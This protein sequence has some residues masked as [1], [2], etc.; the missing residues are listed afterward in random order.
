MYA[1]NWMQ[2]LSEIL[3]RQLSNNKHLRWTVMCAAVKNG[4]E[5]LVRL[6]LSGQTKVMPYVLNPEHLKHEHAEISGAELREIIPALDPAQDGSPS[7]AVLPKSSPAPL[8]PSTRNQSRSTVF[9]DGTLDEDDPDD[10]KEDLG[11]EVCTKSAEETDECLL[12]I[13]IQCKPPKVSIVTMLLDYDPNKQDINR[14]LTHDDP[15][16]YVSGRRSSD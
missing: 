1:C 5:A 14:Q 11:G 12:H 2:V 8:S 3:S 10:Q 6:L 13:A 15:K 16:Q 4:D 7:D 9:S